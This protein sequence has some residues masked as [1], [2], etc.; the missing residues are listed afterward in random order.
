MKWQAWLAWGVGPLAV[1][2]ASAWVGHLRAESAKGR[3]YLATK[4]AS[5]AER[6]ALEAVPALAAANAAWAFG[7]VN[8]VRAT[9]VLALEQVPESDG[10]SRARTFLRFGIVEENPD[11]QA[12]LFAQACVAD[13]SLC[14]RMKEAAER[15]TQARFVSPG[16]HLP[17][18]F[19]G[20]H[21]PI[22]GAPL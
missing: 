14:E 7:P 12:A 2:A 16:N 11:G 5:S 8:A 1:A 15:E 18:Y 17:L 21:P 19:L 6:A 10:K 20:G 4:A 9:S 22:G 3:F 13:A